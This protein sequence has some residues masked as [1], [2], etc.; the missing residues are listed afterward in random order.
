MEIEIPFGAKDSELM[1]WEYTI[2]EDMEAVIKDGKVIVRKK[3][4]EDEKIRKALL[5]CCDDWEKGQ[6][7]CMAEEDVPKIRAYLKKHKDIKLLSW[8][9]VDECRDIPDGHY[10]VVAYNK[11]G[12]FALDTVFNGKLSHPNCGNL[13]AISVFYVPNTDENCMCI[14]EKQKE[15]KSEIKYVYPIFKVGDIVKLKAYNESHQINKIK[16]DNYVL[17]N[18]FTFPIIG[19]DVWEIVEQKPNYCHYGGDPNVERCKWCSAACI[20]RLTEEQKPDIEICP[21]SINGKSYS[22]QKPSEAM[23]SK[24]SNIHPEEYPLTPSKCTK[25]PA[26][27]SDTDMKEAR[28]NLISVCRDWECGRQTTLLPIVAVRARY[29]LEHLTEPKPAEWSKEDERMLS[30]CVKSIETSKQFADSNTFNEAKDK[31]KEWLKSLPERLNLQPKQE[32]SE[33]DEK[34]VRFYEDDYNHKIGNMPMKD[35]VE[36]RLKFKEWL[37]NR[38]KSLRPQPKQEW[39]KEDEKMLNALLSFFPTLEGLAECNM[40]LGREG[41]QVKVID[42]CFAWL[43]SLR[44]QPKRRDTYYDIIHDILASL[45]DMDFTQIT[46]EH[47]ISL[48]NDIRVKCKNAEE[49]AEILDEFQWKP[50]E[51]EKGAL[52]TAIHVLTDERSFPK[53]AAHLQ[54]ILDAFE[55]EEPRKEWKPSEVQMVALKEASDKHWEPDGIE[56]L[57]TLYQ[58]LKKL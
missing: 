20:G 5:R 17:D 14:I 9:A 36:N 56:P 40:I 34:I 46:P 27:W 50:S 47:R 21:H 12:S 2:P 22:E 18:G 4:S 54:N 42:E 35:V 51:Q 58:D 6:Y 15:Q 7:G 43:K 16:D 26:E 10:V 48:L 29:F 3:E 28:A 52:R 37:T 57:Y 30:R 8:R 25:K 55:G 38:L 45:K 41:D 33:E 53:A 49:C 39:S 44:L 1:G 11:P 13:K 32:W 19:Q 31:E 24:V 23:K